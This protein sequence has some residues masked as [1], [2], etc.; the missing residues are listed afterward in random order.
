VVQIDERLD[1]EEPATSA[2]AT[3]FVQQARTLLT[4]LEGGHGF[5]KRY[6]EALQRDPDV[7]LAH[8]ATV[9]LLSTLRE[10]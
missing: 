1:A 3:Q 8:G 6:F 2:E 9:R 7:I 10:E 5:E 4:P